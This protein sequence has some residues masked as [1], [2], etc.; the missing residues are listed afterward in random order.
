M[1]TFTL[2]DQPLMTLPF[3]PGIAVY[4]FVAGAVLWFAIKALKMWS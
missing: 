4:L 3:W 1:I 2:A